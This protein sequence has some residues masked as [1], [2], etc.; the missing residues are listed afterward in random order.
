[1]LADLDMA[2]SCRVGINSV[3]FRFLRYASSRVI[4]IHS[5]IIMMMVK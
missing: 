4:E 2:R 5:L 3:Y 1:M